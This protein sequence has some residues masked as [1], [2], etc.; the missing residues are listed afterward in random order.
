MHECSKCRQLKDYSEFSKWK[1]GY[2]KN[3]KGE[4]IRSHCKSCKRL[5]YEKSQQRK[6]EYREQNPLPPKPKKS[7]EHKLNVRRL[8]WREKYYNDPQFK[9]THSLRSRTRAAIKS[10]GGYKSATTEKLLGCSFEFA[11]EYI[12]QT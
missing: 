1:Y 2:W 5:N 10:Q 3:D 6:K 4:G 7:K 8:Y 11:R 12:S 9:L